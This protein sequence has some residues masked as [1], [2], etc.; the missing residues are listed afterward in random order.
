MT[1]TI[2]YNSFKSLSTKI[3]QIKS[4]DSTS[5]W[6]VRGTICE[7]VS[8]SDDLLTARLALAGLS[9]FERH[10]GA[11]ALPSASCHPN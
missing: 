9:Y 3:A 11:L 1:T 6:C 5:F 8:F 2:P 4:I 10:F 7:F